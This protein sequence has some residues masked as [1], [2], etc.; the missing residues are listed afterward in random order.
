VLALPQLA[1]LLDEGEAHMSANKQDKMEKK[2]TSGAN[3][4]A[5]GFL[6]EKKAVAFF[7]KVCSL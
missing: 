2:L 4:I 7:K 6:Y 3:K 5:Q 1:P